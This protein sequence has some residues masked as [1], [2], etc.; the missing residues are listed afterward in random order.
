MALH[1]G[2]NLAAAVSEA[3]ALG[4]FGGINPAGP[5][6]VREQV[7]LARSRT[8]KPIGVGFITHLLPMLG[9][10]LDVALEEG[11]TVIT[12]SFADPKQWSEKAKEAGATVVCQ[13][14]SMKHAREAVAAGAD[15]LVA[16]GNEA[17]GHTGTMNLLPLLVRLLDLYP[18]TPIL[19]AGGITCGRA[20]AAVLAAG[21]DGAWMG[22]ALLASHECLEV[23]DAYKQAIV[24]SD[25]EDTVYTSVLDII[26]SRIFGLPPW[27]EGIAERVRREPL[28]EHWHGREQE[29]QEKI[30]LIAQQFTES[31]QRGEQSVLMGQGAAA[32]TAV[33]SASDI[34]A[35][36]CD[37]AERL[38]RERPRSLLA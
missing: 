5:G 32:V 7:R 13:V 23:P 28:V 14:Q 35:S 10:A 19:A 11:V 3:G 4:A 20:L 8:S 18:D 16:Q 9:S 17:G 25:G 30:D 26:I 15:V 1:S 12:F 33:R 22:T 2:G 34:I 6:W 37:E 21:A 36:V 24:E 29:L 27:P 31:R 38:L